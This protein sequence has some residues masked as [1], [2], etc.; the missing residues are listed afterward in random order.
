MKVNVDVGDGTAVVAR[1]D[2]MWVRPVAVVPA[3]V[4]ANYVFGLQFSR[5]DSVSSGVLAKILTDSF[6]GKG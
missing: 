4:K 1:A 5:I 3:G 2:V 6:T